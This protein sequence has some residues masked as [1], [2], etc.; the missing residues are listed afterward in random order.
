MIKY[1]VGDRVIVAE[2]NV[3]FLFGSHE[4]KHGKIVAIMP[5]QDGCP[6]QVAI[7]NDARLWCKVKCLEADEKTA[8]PVKTEE[9]IV[10]THDG[11][12]TTATLYGEFGKKESATARCA[13]EDTFD[14]NIGAKLAMER[15]MEKVTPVTVGG[16][17]V[18]DRVNYKGHNGTVICI[19]S[20]NTTETPIGVEFDEWR[21]AGHNC[22]AC[23]IKA[24]KPGTT[25]RCKWC[26]PELL[27]HGETPKYYNGKVVCIA[28]HYP[29]K[30]SIRG[31]TVGK[32]YTVVDGKITNDEN[33]TCGVP[34]KSVEAL[35]AGMGNHFIELKE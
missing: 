31:F 24:G 15:L 28:N 29:N 20:S 18:G 4:G 27:K 16:F 23:D 10:I 11:K 14:F 17:K 30:T 25:S 1:N 12:V 6:Y 19:Q 32:I 7:D 3:D 21:G 26:E 13:P 5:T 22:R 33:L 9:K 35:S 34:Y 2:S 8:N